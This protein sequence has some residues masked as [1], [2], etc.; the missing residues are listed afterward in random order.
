[1]IYRE[2]QEETK[3]DEHKH[4]GMFVFVIMSH[5]MRGDVILD[6]HNQEVDLMKIRDLL[7]PHVFSAMR[8]KPK[9]MIV[10]ACSGGELTFSCFLFQGCHVNFF[11]FENIVTGNY[12]INDHAFFI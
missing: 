4:L 2:I 9:L 11:L 7:S 6:R 5:G 3:R 12:V 8:G 1:M 10:Q